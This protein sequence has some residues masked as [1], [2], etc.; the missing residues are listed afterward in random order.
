[1]WVLAREA[2]QL[3]HMLSCEAIDPATLTKRRRRHP[4]S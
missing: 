4:L 1:M 2:T 3:G